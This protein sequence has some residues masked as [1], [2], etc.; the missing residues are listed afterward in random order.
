MREALAQLSHLRPDQRQEVVAQCRVALDAQE[1]MIGRLRAEGFIALVEHA[2]IV[3][4]ALDIL[5]AN[6]KQARAQEIN[7]A[8]GMI[9]DPSADMGSQE[10]LLGLTFE[11]KN[12]LI[13]QN[14]RI[15]SM[16][17][18][19]NATLEAAHSALTEWESV[20]KAVERQRISRG[21]KRGDMPPSPL[22]G[23][24]LTIHQRLQDT[25]SGL[26]GL[27]HELNQLLGLQYSLE[28]RGPGVEC[29]DFLGI[30]VFG[31]P[32]ARGVCR[33]PPTAGTS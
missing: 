19:L 29:R 21:G 30:F 24:S 4:E 20:L 17:D 18:N 13:H 16:S 2:G 23:R 28:R 25:A 22:E 15:G 14:E 31:L 3:S 27:A 5:R 11:I 8:R 33:P 9:D 7:S 26:R 10:N 32:L 12:S 6:L 1:R